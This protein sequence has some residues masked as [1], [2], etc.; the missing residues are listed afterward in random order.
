MPGLSHACLGIEARELMLA[1]ETR[2]SYPLS[3]FSSFMDLVLAS[4]LLAALLVLPIVAAVTFF[5]FFLSHLLLGISC[6][7]YLSSQGLGSSILS[8]FTF[9]LCMKYCRVLRGGP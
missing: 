2:H 3:Y 4:S 8:R 6:I 5:F 9:Y 1:E 7:L